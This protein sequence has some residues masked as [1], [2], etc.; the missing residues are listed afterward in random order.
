MLCCKTPTLT[1][2]VARMRAKVRRADA[3]KKGEL[4]LFYAGDAKEGTLKTAFLFLLLE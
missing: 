4:A 1:Q 3:E 2:V